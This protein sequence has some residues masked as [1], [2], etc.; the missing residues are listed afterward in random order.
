MEDNYV[1]IDTRLNTKHFES[2][3]KEVEKKLNDMIAD[4][5][6][7]S[8]SKGFKANS[9]DAVTLRKEIERLSNRLV[10]LREQQDKVNKADL[11]N[12]Q[13]SMNSIGK[14]TSG[15]I[16]KVLKWGL[17]LFSIRSAYNF[18][19]GSVSMLSQS[20]E[21]I[22]ADIEYIRWALASTLQPIIE[23]IIKLVY[24][25]LQYVNYVANAW[26][27]VNLFAKASTK[28][29][30]KVNK[31]LKNTRKEA[32]R[33]QTAFDDM[34][35][36]QKDGSIANVGTTPQTDL[37]KML[38]VGEIPDWVQWIADNGET[39]KDIILGIGSAFVTWKILELVNH[40]NLFADGIK[41]FSKVLQ[42]AGIALIIIGIWNAVGDV[43][44]LITNPSWDNFRA[45][46]F[47]LSLAL[48]GL[49]LILIG[50]NSSNPL[51]WISLG[52]GAVGGLI[53]VFGDLLD[54]T[55]DE[56]KELQNSETAIKKLKKARDDLSKSS[57]DYTKAVKNSR[58]ATKVLKELEEKHK[59]SGEALFNAIK[60]GTKDVTT[61]TDE[62]Y[63]VYKAYLDNVDAQKELR[64]KTIALNS[65]Q[66]NL[67]ESTAKVSGAL[68]EEK[69]ALDENFKAM[70]DGYEKGTVSAEKARDYIFAMLSNMDK[71]TRKVF[72]ESLPPSITKAFETPKN[73]IRVLADGTEIAYK[74]IVKATKKTFETDLP[75][76]LAKS[77]TKVG[78]L[79]NKFSSIKNL[80]EK[81]TG[82]KINFS[83]GGVGYAKGGIVT[84]LATGGIVSRPNKGVPV[85][86][87]YMGE[88]GREG[89]IPLTDS[90]AMETLG[91]AIGRYISINA[92][93]PIYMGNR[94]IAKEIRKI[95]AEDDFA[96]N[97]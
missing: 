45:L 81:F 56:T 85:A 10:S 34:N 37:S 35:V 96:Y 70:V 42:G 17:A 88:A 84:K 65:S 49:G 86:S 8:K 91:Q 3:I 74:D 77:T 78:E 13:N 89:I 31:T 68:Y 28:Q 40:L 21:Q 25:L 82:I 22:G 53:S 95:E 61:L 60:I 73:I 63:A 44:D 79:F 41:T 93:V 66:Q 32:Q 47:D 75:N 23:T 20:N 72:I 30:E 5:D 87:A 48:D 6:T 43:I 50:I 15:V 7:M 2:Q 46:I 80:I 18:I 57:S 97:Q 9:Q 92:T 64:D 67:R 59:I 94:Q 38:G 51:G 83:T 54:S 33:L 19:R 29:F 11:Q 16:K 14:S 55:K 1:V 12:A 27:G 36:L 58:D 62:E 90:Q 52:I 26:F 24:K 39:V 69:K 76:S 71:E 4:Y